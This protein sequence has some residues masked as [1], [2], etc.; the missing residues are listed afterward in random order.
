MS[1]QAPYAKYFPTIVP[2]TSADVAAIRTS[3]LSAFLAS[4]PASK[5]KT[6]RDVLLT[7]LLAT[8][9]GGGNVRIDVSY[10]SN[11]DV[12]LTGKNFVLAKSEEGYDTNSVTLRNPA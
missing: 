6:Y 4:L 3:G 1:A 11:F 12:G 5:G 9:T 10:L 8:E 7:R 2:L